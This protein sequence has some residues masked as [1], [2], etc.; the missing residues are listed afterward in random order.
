VLSASQLSLLAIS[1]LLYD[2][3]AWVPA[4]EFSGGTAAPAP[5]DAVGAR[6][7]V[8]AG[9]P[10][11]GAGLEMRLRDGRIGFGYTYAAVV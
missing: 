3:S 1:S 2:G 4:A 8:S 7:K 6:G 5:A 11:C 9:C 10:R